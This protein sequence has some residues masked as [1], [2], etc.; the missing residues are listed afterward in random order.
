MG[1]LPALLMRFLPANLL[2]FL[3]TG[4]LR[5]LPAFLMRL[6]PARLARFLPALLLGLFPALLVRF[7]P[8]LLM[9]FLPTILIR[10]LLALSLGFL[11]AFLNIVT[12][13]HSNLL[14]EF[15]MRNVFTLSTALILLVALL[16]MLVDQLESKFANLFNSSFLLAIFV[17]GL[18][19]SSILCN[20]QQVS[21][22]K[23]LQILC[24][25][26]FLRSF[27]I[28]INSLSLPLLVTFLV[29]LG[30]F[31]MAMLLEE[32]SA[33]VHVGVVALGVALADVLLLLPALLG[34]LG[35]TLGGV[36]RLALLDVL[37]LALFSVLNIALLLVLCLA[38]LGVLNLA[39]CGVLGSARL[40]VLRL[41][42]L[43]VLGLA[44]LLHLLLALGGVLGLALVLVL[45][46]TMIIISRSAMW[47]SV[48]FPFYLALVFLFVFVFL[49]L[50]VKQLLEEPLGLV[51]LH[52]DE[53]DDETGP[54]LHCV[55]DCCGTLVE[56][57]QANL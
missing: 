10:N 11:P 39:L 7:L 44:L 49:V 36:L 55:S 26:L 30:L 29:L 20:F 27:F 5:F 4:F 16:Q 33:V 54:R 18:G 21:C 50:G 57:N 25:S 13:L 56:V 28:V 9:G 42:L 23:F 15:T 45:R 12:F 48:L 22:R 35:G 6:V 3:P 38:L 52:K 47:L 2:G 37:G 46:L 31:L 32:R 19:N 17:L 1:F 34:V 8:A 14:A 51:Q 24:R 40:L 43:L 41:A 53:E